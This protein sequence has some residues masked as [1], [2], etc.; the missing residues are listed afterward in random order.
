MSAY[1]DL[2]KA[3]T[4]GLVVRVLGPRPSRLDRSWAA[5]PQ[6]A[7]DARVEECQDFLRDSLE[8]GRGTL[9]DEWRR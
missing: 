6:K 2:I 8:T 1:E 4:A 3:V 7:R 5:L 9:T